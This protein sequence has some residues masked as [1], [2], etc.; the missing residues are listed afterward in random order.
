MLEVWRGGQVHGIRGQP[1]R[2]NI[3]FLIQYALGGTAVA[4]DGGSVARGKAVVPRLAFA[5]FAASLT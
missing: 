2:A 1:V 5:S 4:L 3:P